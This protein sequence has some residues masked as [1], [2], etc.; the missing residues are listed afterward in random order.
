MLVGIVNLTGKILINVDA[1][2]SAKIIKEN[3]LIKELFREFLFAS[4]FQAK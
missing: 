4:H 2:T 3:D 1:E